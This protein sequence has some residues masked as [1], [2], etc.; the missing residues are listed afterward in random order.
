MQLP[1]CFAPVERLVLRIMSEV[2][3][4]VLNSTELTLSSASI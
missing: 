3:Y 2:T 1:K 4:N